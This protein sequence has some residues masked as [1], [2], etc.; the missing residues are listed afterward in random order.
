MIFGFVFFFQAEDGIRDG[1]VTGVQT[2]ALPIMKAGAA[3][4]L[5][6]PFERDA[7]L[8]AIRSAIE[9]SREALLQA[10]ELKRLRERY[11]SLTPREREVRDAYRSRSLLSSEACRSASRLR[12]IALR[13][14]FNSASRS[15][16]FV[17]NSAAPAF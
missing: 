8:N 5:T 3:E 15:N 10:S 2:C 14:A 17:R 4:F 16:G 11:A 13:I 9:R 1:H 12:S 6:K 7:L